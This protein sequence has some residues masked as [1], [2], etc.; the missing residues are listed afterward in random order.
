MANKKDL[1]ELE[2][3]AEFRMRS[4]RI[5]L[6]FLGA[7]SPASRSYASERAVAPSAEARLAR[8]LVVDK[9]D[10]AFGLA[11][12]LNPHGELPT[13]GADSLRMKVCSPPC[14]LGGNFVLTYV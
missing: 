10:G 1:E 9:L 11:V 2:D 8:P 7:G 13:G 12:S 5:M 3:L 14:S 4:F 6:H